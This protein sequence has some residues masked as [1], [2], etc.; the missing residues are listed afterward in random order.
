MISLD[1]LNQK[2]LIKI[3]LKLREDNFH[4]MCLTAKYMNKYQMIMKKCNPNMEQFQ[5]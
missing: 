5:K 1:K 2:Q 4:H 3:I